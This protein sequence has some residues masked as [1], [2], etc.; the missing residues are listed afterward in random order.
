MRLALLLPQAP[1]VCAPSTSSFLPTC[2]RLRARS[3]R[4]TSFLPLLDAASPSIRF[5]SLALRSPLQSSP[6]A[7]M[8]KNLP[9]LLVAATF[10][11][12]A[13]YLL[14]SAPDESLLDAF[15]GGTKNGRHPCPYADVLGLDENSPNPHGAGGPGGLPPVMQPTHSN[16][17]HAHLPHEQQFDVSA[18]AAR[19]QAEAAAKAA[20]TKLHSG[21]S[22]DSGAAASAAE[23]GESDAAYVG[24]S[25]FDMSPP[26]PPQHEQEHAELKEEL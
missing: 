12:L 1:H 14:L 9:L 23:G 21:S 25:D 16:P 17:A 20:A 7:A 8:A 15:A 19:Q 6:S 2:C 5:D 11:S 13:A 18:E 4:S 3:D 22:S 10:F 24:R 26:V